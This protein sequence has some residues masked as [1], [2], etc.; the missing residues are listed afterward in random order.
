MLHREHSGH[1]VANVTKVLVVSTTLGIIA[2]Y[3]RGSIVITASTVERDSPPHG[4]YGGT[5]Q[6]T[7]ECVNS[8]AIYATRNLST[9]SL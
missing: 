3:T 2:S 9:N 8:G 6:G 1:I 7:P 5:Y 4:H